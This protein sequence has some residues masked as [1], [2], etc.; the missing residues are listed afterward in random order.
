M[1]ELQGDLHEAFHWR[2][3]KKGLKRA[4]WLF[5]FEVIRSLRFSTLKPTNYLNQYLMMYRNYIKTGW[6]FLKKHKLY[7][8]LNILGL[9]LGISFC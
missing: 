7:S 3:E 2:V 9:A 5:I 8:T 6:R 1:E 4:R